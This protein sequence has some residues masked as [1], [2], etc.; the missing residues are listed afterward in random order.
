MSIGHGYP[1]WEVW[2]RRNTITGPSRRRRPAPDPLTVSSTKSETRE[3]S[4]ADGDIPTPMTPRPAQR[5]S[6]RARLPASRRFCEMARVSSRIDEPRGHCVYQDRWGGQLLEMDLVWIETEIRPAW[7]RFVTSTHPLLPYAPLCCELTIR[8]IAPLIIP[9]GPSAWSRGK[10]PS[11]WRVDHG[12]PQF[13]PRRIRN[14]R[15]VA[16][17]FRRCSRP[18]SMRPTSLDP[19]RRCRFHLG[20]HRPRSHP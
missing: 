3:K 4:T 19:P 7:K 10:R 8:P 6:P 12:C 9:K 14:S 17:G 11:D 18:T 20:G 1:Q 13:V 2:G 16:R 5:K 15:F